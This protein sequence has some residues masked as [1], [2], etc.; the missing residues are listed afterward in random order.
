MLVE[1]V[2][3][4]TILS[5]L[6]LLIL[7]FISI[8]FPKHRVWPPPDKR[9]WQYV[10]VWSLTFATIAGIAALAVLDWDTFILKHWIRHYIGWI[11]FIVGNAFALWGL[12]TLG[13]RASSGL[14][15]KLVTDGPYKFSRNPQYVGD[16]VA[17]IGVI[18]MANSLYTT[19][20][21]LLAIILFLVTPFAEE[22]WLREKYGEEYIEYCKRTPRYL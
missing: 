16:I 14:E 3:M 20:A 7:L 11:L 9:T 12:K 15:Y 6:L 18:L 21:C 5:E 17:L 22:P 2:F 19:I 13:T 1:I 10:V 4:L 8:F